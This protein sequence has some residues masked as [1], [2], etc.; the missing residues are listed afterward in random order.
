MDTSHT[1][2]T[3]RRILVAVLLVGGAGLATARVLARPAPAA[4]A[5][6]ARADRTLSVAGS[7][8]DRAASSGEDSGPGCDEAA[9]AK[10][11]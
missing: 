2:R 3:L 7:F 4:S 11:P 5:R 9:L 8:E 1:R 6:P 10:H